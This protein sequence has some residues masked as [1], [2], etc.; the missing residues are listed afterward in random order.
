MSPLKKTVPKSP[1]KTKASRAVKPKPPAKKT[2]KPAKK[3]RAAGS[4]SPSPAP[5]M[6]QDAL[7]ALGVG[8]YV[9]QKSRFADVNPIFEKI[10]GYV[11]KEIIGGDILAHI[12]PEDRPGYKK[13]VQ[14]NLKKKNPEPYEYRWIRKGGEIV[15]FLETA[16][17]T[18]HLGKPAIL[19]S[20][21]DVSLY[22]QTT[23]SRELAEDRYRALI[24]EID[25]GY[26]ELDLKG[27]YT[28][29]NQTSANNIGYAPQ[30]MIGQNYRAFTSEGGAKKMRSIFQTV[31]KTG[32]SVTGREVEFLHKDKTP[33]IKELSA[34]LISDAAGRPCGFRS[35]SRDVTVKRQMEAMLKQSDER[36]KALFDHSLDGVFINDLEGRFMDLNQVALDKLGYTRDEIATLDFASFLDEDQFPEALRIRRELLQTGMQTK[37]A[38]FQLKCKDG[39]RIYVE[40]LA[41]VVYRDGK[42]HAVI[43]ISRDLTDRRKMEADLRKSEERYRTILD[44]IQEGYCELDE[45]G[46]VLFVNDAAAQ[47]IGYTSKDIIGTN[48]GRYVSPEDVD[49][50]RGDFAD[51]CKTGRPKKFLEIPMRTKDGMTRYIHFSAAPIRDA[52][53]RTSGVRGIIRDVTERKWTEEALLQSEARYLSI[54]ESVGEAYFETNLRGVM[55]FINDKVCVDLGYTREEVLTLNPHAFQTPEDAKKTFA[56]FS[57]VYKTGKPKLSYHYEIIRKDG[58]QAV[59]DLSISLMRDAQGKPIGFRGLSR[60]IT[61]RKVMEDA[62][63]ASEARAR[64]IIDTIPD[65][66]FEADPQGR[67]TYVNQAFQSLIGR[68]IDELSRMNQRDYFGPKAADNVSTLY[69]TVRKTDLTIKNAELQIVNK[70]GEERIVNLSVSPIR[71]LKGEHTGFHG[72][73]RD[74]TEKKEAEKMIFDSSTKLMEY[75]EEL[76]MRVSERTAEL[77]KARLEA[78]AASRAKSEFLANISH[79]FQTPLNSIVGFTKVLKDRLFGELNPKQDEFVR[80]I[81]EGGETLSRLLNEIIDISSVSTGRTRVNL[82]AVSIPQALTKAV[83]IVQDQIKEKKHVLTVDVALDADI[84]IEGDDEK[85]RH[86]FFHLLSN[87]VKYTPAGGTITVE[88]KRAQNRSGVDGV[89]VCVTDNGPGIKPADLPRLFQHFGRLE[90]TYA[91]ESSGIGVGLSLTRQLTELHNGE[92]D[93]QSEYGAGSAF[94]VF[95][96]LTQPRV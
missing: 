92:I 66:Y 10:S 69:E 44:D 31:Y 78:E 79:E 8:T 22:R 80:Y 46:N 29:V 4:A 89:T 63:K 56:I 40:V 28:F 2:K 35:M 1:L 39:R 50:L 90:S 62:L 33:R 21:M 14:T 93:V 54:I 57:E 51:I 30:E 25:L 5:L 3:I 36:F 67:I 74:V 77:E 71:D 72:I 70:N 86:I 88:A 42:P 7:D 16:E 17:P 9:I 91:R 84:A 6:A 87:A 81:S 59:F 13:N 94:T 15:I 45:A 24:E 68:G 61:D 26:G 75:S 85:I 82:S 47:I 18:K 95:L 34:T 41:A 32:K 49:Q 73:L 48:L 58:S 19:A 23:E 83:A 76:E 27:N 38:E 20:V 11:R 43:G 64:T 96:P 12:H 52:S 60:D 65:P 37:P 55:T 53:G